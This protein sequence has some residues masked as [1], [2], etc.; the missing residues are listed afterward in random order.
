[1]KNG[2]GK[3][4]DETEAAGFDIGFTT[5]ISS[6]SAFKGKPNFSSREAMKL[7]RLLEP[8]AAASTVDLSLKYDLVRL[9]LSD[10]Y[11]KA[12]LGRGPRRLDFG[13]GL[14]ANGKSQQSSRREFHP[15]PDVRGCGGR[16]TGSRLSSQSHR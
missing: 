11:P 8:L 3:E 7:Y 10:P 12:E 5:V 4:T 1:M 15:E 9:I 6:R 16:Q 2:F 14:D 13:K